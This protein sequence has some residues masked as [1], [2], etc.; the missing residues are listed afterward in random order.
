MEYG[1][2]SSAHMLQI[3]VVDIV[4][5]E[6]EMKQSTPKWR[7]SPSRKFFSTVTTATLP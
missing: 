5:L 6:T 3:L 4:L 7:R 2:N 1:Y